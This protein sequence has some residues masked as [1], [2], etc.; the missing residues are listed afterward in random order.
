[1]NFGYVK[2]IRP[3]HPTLRQWIKGYYVQQS[4]QEDFHTSLT[5]YQNITTT[6]SV[7]KDSATTSSGRYRQQRFQAGKGFSA[8]LVGLVDKYQQ[9]EFFG[10]ID[11]LGIVFYP[12]GINHFLRQPLGDLLKR[13]YSFFDCYEDAFTTFL[14]AVYAA[15]KLEQKRD[16]LDDFFLHRFQAPDLPLLFKA[17]ELLTTSDEELKVQVLAA[18]LGVS[19]RTLLR[20]FKKYLGYSVEEY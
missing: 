7:Y 18:K 10:P 16:L 11:R 3:Q 5:F 12:L 2:F 20:R 1:M 6:I 8:L 14:P 19:R 13:H 15:D 9:V 4:N 17:V